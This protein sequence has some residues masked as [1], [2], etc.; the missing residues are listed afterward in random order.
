M[1]F[2]GPG[3]LRRNDTVF[4]FQ[5]HA[6]EAAELVPLHPVQQPKPPPTKPPKSSPPAF[7]TA[8]L[9]QGALAASTF[10]ALGAV[11]KVPPPRDDD[12]DED[13]QSPLKLWFHRVVKKSLLW[14][15][16]TADRAFF[17]FSKDHFVRRMATKLVQWR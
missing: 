14:K 13:K 5:R 17:L 16:L 3:R 1:A 6:S 11:A 9:W 10:A 7:L 4:D 8:S 2:I 15:K 12:D